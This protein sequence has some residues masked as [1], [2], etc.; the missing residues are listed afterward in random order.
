MEEEEPNDQLDAGLTEGSVP[1]SP[2]LKNV[3]F[4]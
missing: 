4:A 3:E 1:H 2:S